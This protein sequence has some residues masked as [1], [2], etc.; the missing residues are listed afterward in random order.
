M[1]MFIRDGTEKN[2]TRRL[3]LAKMC[4]LV[5]AA[6]LG[7]LLLRDTNALHDIGPI[8]EFPFPRR[9]STLWWQMND[10]NLTI[11]SAPLKQNGI[12]LCYFNDIGAE[13]WKR[14]DGKHD[15]ANIANEVACQFEFQNDSENIHETTFFLIELDKLGLLE[16]NC[17]FQL[18][19]SEIQRS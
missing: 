19:H 18:E 13:I 5:P 10:G 7:P 9:R 17:V 1:T 15:P 4:L 12:P 3:F 16:G 2:F 11:Y 14:L 6:T 8:Q